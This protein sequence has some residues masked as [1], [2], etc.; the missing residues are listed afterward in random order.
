MSTHNSTSKGAGA[1]LGRNILLLMALAALVATAVVYAATVGPHR[2]TL[3]SQEARIAEL[4]AQVAQAHDDA[5]AAEQEA[6]RQVT[7]LDMSRATA[8]GE[9]AERL[10]RSAATWTTGAQY[11]EARQEL[12]DAWDLAPDS[13]FMTVFM[14]GEAQGAYR[15][16]PSGEVH[17]AFPGANSQLASFE[18]TLVSATG[19]EWSYLAVVEIRVTSPASGSVTRP[20]AVSYTTGPDGA[21]SSIEAYPA[22]KEP[23]AS[24]RG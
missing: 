15:T 17:F 4:E 7:G 12:L 8:D 10:M 2:D 5:E 3:A 24:G 20:I 6:V 19:D 14:P 22:N 9:T 13:Q 16:D 18:Q 23:V 11:I 21:V 1:W